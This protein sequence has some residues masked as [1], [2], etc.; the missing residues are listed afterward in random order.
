MARPDNIWGVH[1]AWAPVAH[2]SN[3]AEDI[4]NNMVSDFNT[5]TRV[6]LSNGIQLQTIWAIVGALYDSVGDRFTHASV[7]SA[8][9][10]IVARNQAPG[11]DEASPGLLL[12]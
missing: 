4:G 8:P 6:A 11:G 9:D 1:E 10:A 5:I 7:R 12:T 2:I 3:S